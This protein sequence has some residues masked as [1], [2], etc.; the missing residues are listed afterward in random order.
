MPSTQTKLF[1][2]D[3]NDHLKVRVKLPPNATF[4]I[5][6]RE[7]RLERGPVRSPFSHVPLALKHALLDRFIQVLNFSISG[8]AA[9][10]DE[11]VYVPIPFRTP[12]RRVPTTS[13]SGPNRTNLHAGAP[14]YGAP[15][16][17]YMKSFGGSA[18]IRSAAAGPFSGI[19]QYL[20][21][22]ARL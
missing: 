2:S 9:A 14:E 10:A 22:D 11:Y 15:G 4:D 8:V 7:M 1:G 17:A 13:W 20:K 18:Y 3:Y 19:D 12:M 16:A 21:L 5:V 6:I